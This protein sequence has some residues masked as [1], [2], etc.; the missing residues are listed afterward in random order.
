MALTHKR[1]GQVLNRKHTIAFFKPLIRALL[2]VNSL[3]LNRSV[4]VI[5]SRSKRLDPLRLGA[6][7][8]VWDLKLVCHT[9]I[10]IPDRRIWP[11]Q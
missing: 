10:S 11:A 1:Q 2:S 5:G 8:H 3:L 9:H 4:C 7:L 6:L